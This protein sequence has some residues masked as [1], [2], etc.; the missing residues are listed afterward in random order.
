MALTRCDMRCVR[1]SSRVALAYP[2]WMATG[3]PILAR[4]VDLQRQSR[5]VLEK[6]RD[7]NQ[8]ADYVKQVDA[9]DVG[10]LAKAIVPELVKSFGYWK[11]PEMTGPKNQGEIQA[12]S[13]EWSAEDPSA[14]GY[15]FK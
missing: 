6:R 3:D 9:L 15:G 13:F 2:R 10:A 7:W 1:A 11:D 5:A 4:I 8:H 14:M 12:V